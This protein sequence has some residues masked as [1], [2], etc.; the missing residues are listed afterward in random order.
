MIAPVNRVWISDLPNIQANISEHRA[1]KK[2]LK[3]RDCETV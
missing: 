2:K 3:L 1:K